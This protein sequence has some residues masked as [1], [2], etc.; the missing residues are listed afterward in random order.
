MT[1]IAERFAGSLRREMLDHVLVVDDHHLDRIGREYATF[2][3]RARPHQGIGQRVPD[4]TRTT[5]VNGQ[6]VANPV[7]GGLHHEYRKPA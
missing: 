2:F 6:I 5:N 1:A 3:N 4:G 7:L